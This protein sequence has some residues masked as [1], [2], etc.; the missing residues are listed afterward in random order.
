MAF[1]QRLE[2]YERTSQADVW[3]T[4]QVEEQCNTPGIGACYVCSGCCKEP[5]LAGG[6]E[7]NGVNVP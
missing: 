7:G 3:R 2:K 4:V 1:Q 5:S 6:A